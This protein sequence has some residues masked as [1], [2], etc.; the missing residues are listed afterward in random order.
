MVEVCNLSKHLLSSACDLLGSGGMLLQILYLNGIQNTG[1]HIFPTPLMTHTDLKPENVLLVNS[2][3]EIFYDAR[4]VNNNTIL[5]HSFIINI[6][7]VETRCV[8]CK[9]D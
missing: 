6:I 3:Y 7:V 9:I 2:D 5:T 8:C 4:R 1:H